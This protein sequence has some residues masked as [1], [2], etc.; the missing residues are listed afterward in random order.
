MRPSP[1]PHS[2]PTRTPRHRMHSL[3]TGQSSP[4][5]VLSSSNFSTWAPGITAGP[6]GRP[7][8]M[9]GSASAGPGSGKQEAHRDSGCMPGRVVHI[10]RHS[11]I[12]LAGPV[13][14]NEATGSGGGMGR[15]EAGGGLRRCKHHCNTTGRAR[16]EPRTELLALHYEQI[17]QAVNALRGP[18]RS[19]RNGGGRGE[20]GPDTGHI[21][22]VGHTPPRGSKGR[23]SQQHPTATS[24]SLNAQRHMKACVKRGGAP[25]AAQLF[26]CRRTG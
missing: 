8:L 18:N 26:S 9:A 10:R 21:V 23:P 17:F 1:H 24:P 2:P 22:T 3:Y 12:T 5:S 15:Q 16:S 11:S 14:H 13:A 20:G 19:V 4:Y 7:M 6:I 25:A